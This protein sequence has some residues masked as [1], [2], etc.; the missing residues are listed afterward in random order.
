MAETDTEAETE[1]KT[2]NVRITR[3]TPGI[4]CFGRKEVELEVFIDFFTLLRVGY[5]SHGAPPRRSCTRRKQRGQYTQAA[6][7]RKT[8]RSFGRSVFQGLD[9]SD[10]WKAAA[11]HCLVCNALALGHT[12]N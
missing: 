8:A 11:P 6:N 9:E 4:T 2:A 1:D 10:R 12:L 3:R 5:L 7:L